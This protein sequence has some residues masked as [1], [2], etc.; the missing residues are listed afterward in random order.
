MTGPKNH[1]KTFDKWEGGVDNKRKAGKTREDTNLRQEYIETFLEIVKMRNIS[2]AAENLFLSQSALSSRLHALEEE[3]NV[4]LFIRKKGNR[5]VALTP[6]GKRFVP[7][8]ERW[9]MLL[10]DMETLSN[11]NTLHV[12]IGSID[13]INCV[14]MAP[15]YPRIAESGLSINFEII[16]QLSSDI[17][18]Y[19]ADQD[20]DFGIVA[21]NGSRTDVIVKPFFPMKM[22]V[23]VNCSAEEGISITSP[24]QLKASDGIYMDYGTEMR[25]WRRMYWSKRET[26]VSIDSSQILEQCL[27]VPNRWALVPISVFERMHCRDKL[28]RCDF[29]ENNPPDRKCYYIIHKNSNLHHSKR[30]E[31]FLD[32]MKQ[33]IN[34]D[35]ALILL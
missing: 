30:W 12:R 25:E 28:Y 29:R 15:L 4:P 27:S 6:Q 7:I 9:V 22:C 1:L 17:Y 8:A 3:L 2:S 33:Q 34:S 19:V 20:Y 14:L 24:H 35:P 31:R 10:R 5:S 18:D 26:A 23:V 16:T 11:D 32:L 21:L 13:S